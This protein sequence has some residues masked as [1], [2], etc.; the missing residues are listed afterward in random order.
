MEVLNHIIVCNLRNV[1]VW[2]MISSASV[3]EKQKHEVGLYIESW[4]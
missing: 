1:H 4:L 3:N 2:I